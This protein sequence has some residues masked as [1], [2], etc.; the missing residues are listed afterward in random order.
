MTSK[1]EPSAETIERLDPDG[2]YREAY[3]D[4]V[5]QGRLIECVVRNGQMGYQAVVGEE[6][7]RVVR[8]KRREA[9]RLAQLVHTTLK[10]DAPD[11]ELDDIIEGLMRALQFF[12]SY[13]PEAARPIIAESIKAG[14][15]QMLAKANIFALDREFL[16]R[17]HENRA[18]ADSP[19]TRATQN[20]SKRGHHDN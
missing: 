17:H 18:G 9:V 2:K 11:A 14:L 4:L 1:K 3:A 8:A 13:M 20:A 5:E 12:M 19:A 6:D 16:H 15:P 7:Q 10:A